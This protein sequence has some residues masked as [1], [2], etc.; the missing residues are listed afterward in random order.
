MLG[1]DVAFCYLAREVGG[2]R[3]LRWWSGSVVVGLMLLVAISAAALWLPMRKVVVEI[4]Q[5]AGRSLTFGPMMERTITDAFNLDEGKLV[6]LPVAQPKDESDSARH[7]WINNPQNMG[8]LRSHGVN[9]VN[10]S[11]ELNGVDIEKPLELL[12]ADWQNMTPDR[13]REKLRAI[14]PNRNRAHWHFSE[15]G[16]YGFQTPAGSI[17]L[18]QVLDAKPSGVRIRYKLVQNSSNPRSVDPARSSVAAP[19][20]SH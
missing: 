3:G 4:N 1:V 17:G 5:T 8:W 11:H 9:L 18:L 20:P 15:L 6:E 13:L 14:A 7:A 10:D 19:T 2:P 16:T 12:P